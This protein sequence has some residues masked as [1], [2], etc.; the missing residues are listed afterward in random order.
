MSRI[1]VVEDQLSLLS[2]LKKGLEEENFQ[3]LTA[4]TGQSAYAVL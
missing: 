3:V 2:S 4:S 1:L